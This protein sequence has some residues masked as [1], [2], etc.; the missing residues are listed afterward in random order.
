M[1]V[2]FQIY[3]ESWL[4]CISGKK[5]SRGG[6]IDPNIKSINTNVD[7][8]IGFVIFHNPTLVIR[9]FCRSS[10]SH[11]PHL[12][13]SY[14]FEI[15]FPLLLIFCLR[16]T[17]PYIVSPALGGTLQMRIKK[18]V[19]NLEKPYESSRRRGPNPVSR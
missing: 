13:I 14:R 4:E 16:R 2:I 7:I 9:W 17:K 8:S 1:H 15:L 5:C 11:P 10:L 3:V 12:F 6:Q 19:G 18:D